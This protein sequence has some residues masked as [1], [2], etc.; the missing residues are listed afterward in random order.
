MT[1]FLISWQFK[2]SYAALRIVKNCLFLFDAEGSTTPF[3]IDN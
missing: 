2:L 1:G 3:L